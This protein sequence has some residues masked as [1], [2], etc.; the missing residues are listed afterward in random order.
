MNTLF[1]HLPAEG[2]EYQAWRL[3]GGSLG[4]PDQGSLAEIA[5]AAGDAAVVA[6]V[7]GSR[8]LFTSATVS[9]KQL[10]QA[11]QNLAWLIEEQTGEDA[12]NLHVLA[13]PTEAGDQTPLLAVQHQYLQQT[14]D[15]LRSAGLHVLAVL[16]DL[17]LLPRDGS[18]WQLAELRA[19]ETALRTADFAGAVLESDLL[20]LML[21]AALNERQSLPA[22]APVLAV[23]GSDALQ[24]RVQEFAAGKSLTVNADTGLRAESVLAA[25]TDWSAHPANLLQ[26][27]F[28]AT[29][30]F[31]LPRGLQVAA[32]F[33][34]AAFALQLLA[35]W[36]YF[37][38]YRYQANRIGDAAV[39]QYKSVYADERLRSS[40]PV[41]EVRKRLTGHQREGQRGGNVLPALTRI[42]ESM[43]GSG[44]NAQRVDFTAGVLTLDVDARALADIDTLKQKLEGQGFRT[45]IVSANAQGGIIRGRL[46]VEGGA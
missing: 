39:A 21:E 32:V 24:Q 36:A 18:D 43:Q 45:E 46:R 37:G 40:R 23:A 30:R 25:G 33:I 4:G 20:E 3:S 35:E 27:R 31:S 8:C 16:P 28:A 12:D 1:L 7:P 17:F 34:A 5:A 13:M 10:R 6:F 29:T 41:E 9:E 42:A 15:E 26:G 11:S 2:G 19:G 44:L 14:L 38:Y 22:A